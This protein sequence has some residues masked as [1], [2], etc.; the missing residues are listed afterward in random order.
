MK[1]IILFL[2]ITTC[3]NS[4]SQNSVTNIPANQIS[5]EELLKDLDT[6]QAWITKAH[7]DPYRF[8]TKEKLKNQFAI[9]KTKIKQNKLM[10]SNSFAGVVMPIIAELRDGHAQVF[11]S[12][13]DVVEGNVFFPLKFVFIN[14]TP[15]VIENFSDQ[16]IDL[17]AKIISING[18]E[19]KDFFD[20]IIPYLHRDGDIE[21]VRYKRLQ[22]TTYLTRV[23]VAL[24]MAKETYNITLSDNGKIKSY[25]LNGLSQ[26]D[27]I[28]KKKKRTVKFE[29]L[30]FKE[31]DSLDATALLDIN[32]FNPSYYDKG[33]FYNRIDDII[34]DL[35]KGNYKNLII[36]LRNNIGGEDSYQMYLL[37][38]LLESKFSMNAEITF[39]QNNYKFL[40]DGKHYDIDPKCFKKNDKGTYDATEYLWKDHPTL[41]EFIPFSN[42][43]RG[44]VIVLINGFT[45]SAGSDFAAMLHFHKRAIFIGQET[46]GSYIGNVSGFIPTL[47]LPNSGV[48]VNIPLISIK[49]P[50]FNSN[51]TN[52][53]VL[54]DIE[55]NSSLEDVLNSKDQIF[56]EAIN[57]LK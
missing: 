35:D 40:P 43:F 8:T 2:L 57:Y 50:F 36:D 28:G 21:T 5:A 15:F 23:L 24:D 48:Y 4:R 17:G 11:L 18:T 47:K 3:T 13:L 34:S 27:Y 37:R 20:E 53:G 54:P 26:Q 25:S 38:Y 46:G 44:R 39:M 22:N 9:A 30:Q 16:Q 19:A 45:F 31:I 1:L 41:G 51:F 49:R 42:R 55:V 33:E 32:T 56:Q 52:R 7:G 10:T 6:L 12:D 14:K 29:P